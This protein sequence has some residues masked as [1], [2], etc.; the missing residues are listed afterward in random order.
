MSYFKHTRIRIL[1][2]LTGVDGSHMARVNCRDSVVV[3]RMAS[4]LPSL[5]MRKE[6]LSEVGQ[7]V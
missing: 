4:V 3:D 1:L 2:K 7:H 5:N 6:A